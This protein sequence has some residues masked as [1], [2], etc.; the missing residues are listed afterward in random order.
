MEIRGSFIC[1]SGSDLRRPKCHEEVNL[2]KTTPT[3][4]L[5][6]GRIK[7][8]APRSRPHGAPEPAESPAATCNISQAGAVHLLTSDPE[9]VAAL[10]AFIRTNLGPKWAAWPGGWRGEIEAALI[11]AVLSIR[12]RYGSPDTGVR[13]AV[14]LYRSSC[15]AAGRPLDDLDRLAAADPEK[16]AAVLHSRQ[17]TSGQ[18]KTEAIIAAA[19]KLN[20]AGVHR[21][22][23]LEPDAPAHRAAYVGVRGLGP[24][25]WSYLTMLLG[26]PGV[27]ADTWICRFVSRALHRPVSSPEAEALVIGAADQLQVGRTALD[28][29]IWSVARR[30]SAD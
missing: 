24:V 27:K 9:D 1:E 28:H 10:V 7:V 22:A 23:D 11:D 12:S 6:C 16:L 20:A 17:R 26:H 3:N 13:G 8:T 14:K 2:N 5:Q 19:Q 21:A 29:A 18:L 15:A 30:M 4:R 25:T